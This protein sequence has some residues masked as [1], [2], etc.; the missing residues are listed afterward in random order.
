MEIQAGDDCTNLKLGR[1]ASGL[2]IYTHLG[3]RLYVIDIKATGL[4]KV[5]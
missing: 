1:R 2:G 5:I 3:V 4:D